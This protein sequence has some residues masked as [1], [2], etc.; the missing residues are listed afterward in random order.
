MRRK[1]G[2]YK[3]LQ[4]QIKRLV[5]GTELELL[6]QQRNVMGCKL[7]LMED[8]LRSIVTEYNAGPPYNEF[9]WLA[10]KQRAEKVL[11]K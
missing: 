1:S 9:D 8:T 7:R 6:Y 2:R 5:D 10:W 4:S 11:T 3:R